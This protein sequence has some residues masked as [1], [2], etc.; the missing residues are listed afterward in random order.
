MK[1]RKFRQI[2]VSDSAKVS[3]RIYI[4]GAIFACAYGILVCRAISF[5]LKNNEDLDRVAMRQY[6]TA[7]TQ[8]TKRGKILDTAGRELAI[9]TNVESVYASPRQIESPADA[10]ASV[11][12]T[13]GVDRR[14]L[15]E[16]LST[17][18][19]F[20]WVARRVEENRAKALMA[21]NIKGIYVMRESSR[22]YPGKTL[23]STVLG[24]VGFD[25]EPLGGVE[26]ALND[27]LSSRKKSGD[28]KRDARGHL[29]LSP[30]D[31]GE[32]PALADV[33]LTIDRTLQ[34]IAERELVRAAQNARAKGGVAIVVDVDTGAI[35]AMANYPMFDPNRYGDYEQ[36]SWRNRAITDAYEPGS[37]FKT[38]IVASAIEAGVATSDDIFDCEGGSI[39]IGFNVVH[40]SHSYGKLSVADI[41]KV[42]SNIGAY[43]VEQKLGMKAAYDAIRAFGF[44]KSSN[45]DL[46]GE[47]PGLLSSHERW[48][49][50]QFA[51]IAF[52]QG[53]ATTPTQ[54]VMAFAAIANGGVLYKPYVVK[55]IAGGGRDLYLGQ[56]EIVSRPLSAATAKTMTGLLERVTQKGGTGTQAASVEYPVAG[57]TGTAQKVEPR[58]GRYAI[59]KYYASFIGFAPSDKPRIAVYVGIDEPSGGAYYGGQVAAPVFRQIVDETL[60]YQKVPG[61]LVMTAAN[62]GDAAQQKNEA[63]EL[64]LVEAAGDEEKIVTQHGE[65]TFRLPD[66]R[67]LT[68]KGV[69][70]AGGPASI[71]WHFVGSGIAVRQSPEP[72]SIVPAGSGCTVEFESFL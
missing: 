38:V 1:I 58:S 9:D 8:S 63:A 20:V 2:E 17:N 12:K 6:Q 30:M 44:G 40:D 43:K 52:G 35:L 11:A 60:H 3:K 45:I 42:S 70:E 18:R 66:L 19:K 46:P 54:M 29:Y 65:Q 69:L 39:K 64:A 37:T 15:L 53:I 32:E 47:I 28:V 4:I 16:K 71:A 56:P 57:K 50:V 62:D 48:S 27:V 61:S 10:A 67:G 72:G 25:A 41:I 13:L 68:M 7:V 24:A 31:D 5:H 51:T 14:K 59:G 21:L 55:K 34:H 23:A 33:Y 22:S 49:E 26:L 36:S